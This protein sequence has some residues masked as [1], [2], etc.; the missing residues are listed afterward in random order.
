MLKCLSIKN[1]ALIRDIT[2]EF[3]EGLNLLTGETGSGKSMIISALSL[4]YG[5]RVYADQIRTGESRGEV[6]GHFMIPSNL[7]KGIGI[8][9]KKLVLKRAFSREGQSKAY[10]NGRGVPLKK[11]REVGTRISVIHGQHDQQALRDPGMHLDLLDSFTGNHAE[12]KNLA[13][14]YGKIMALEHGLKALSLCDA[15]RELKRDMLSFQIQEIAS[16][17]LQGP[18]E[19][20]ALVKEREILNN[21]EKIMTLCQNTYAMLYEDQQALYDLTNKLILNLEKLK[22]FDKRFDEYHNAGADWPFLIEE[23]AGY[24]KSFGEKIEYNPA[25]LSFVEERLAC[26]ERLERK[27]GLPVDELQQHLEK[28]KREMEL[29]S[30]DQEQ[31]DA[32]ERALAAASADFT[33]L[34]ETLSTERKKAAVKMERI[35]ERELKHLAMEKAKIKINFSYECREDSHVKHDGVGVA[36]AAD[37]FDL[38]EFLLSSNPGEEFKPLSRIAS[39]GELSRIMLALRTIGARVRDVHTIIFDEVDSGIGGK[40]ADFLGLKLRELSTKYQVIC[41][42][43][44]PQIASYALHHLYVEKV[45]KDG[46]T[47]TTINKISGEDRV[48]EIARMLAG[49]EITKS[50]L[51][52]ARNLLSHARLKA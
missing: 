39:G 12:R 26:I 48:R 14:Y 33:I 21:A 46:R 2:L 30:G 16:A 34:A 49:R 47:C 32:M 31:T 51:F 9:G 27:Y 19:K 18:D 13:E 6:E 36:F 52:H 42:T 23:I 10:I 25:R 8:K 35:L 5:E 20:Y 4:L 11:I 50:S 15:E 1:F 17:E 44:L 28:L 7:A 37:G 45:E 41:I 3:S 24:V 43:H 22:H 40:A 38:V 29:L